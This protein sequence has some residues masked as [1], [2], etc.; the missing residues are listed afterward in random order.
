MAIELGV[1]RVT[2]GEP[3]RLH[4][5]GV[6][7]EKQL[8]DFIEADPTLLGDPIMLIGRQVPTGH[9]G[10]IDL[11]GIDA[12]ARLHVLELKRDRLLVRS[13]PSCSTTARG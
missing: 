8:E 3:I 5:T 6:P 9:G 12:D 13:S 7:L 11:I 10:F 1:W 2:N 4:S